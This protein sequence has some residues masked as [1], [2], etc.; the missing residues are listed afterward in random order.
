MCVWK[1]FQNPKAFLISS[2]SS[3]GYLICDTI[4]EISCLEYRRFWCV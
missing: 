1:K 4:L 3:K 2:I